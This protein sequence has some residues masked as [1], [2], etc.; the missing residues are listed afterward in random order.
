MKL[1]FSAAPA[2]PPAAPIRVPI[3][4]TILSLKDTRTIYFHDQYFHDQYFLDFK[5]SNFHKPT[6]TTHGISYHLQYCH[7]LSLADPNRIRTLL[8]DM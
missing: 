7:P 6:C 4:A 3:P 5:R 2:A 8:K 1:K